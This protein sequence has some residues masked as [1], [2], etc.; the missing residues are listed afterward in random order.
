MNDFR[1]VDYEAIAM[2]NVSATQQIKKEN[3]AEVK[4]LQEENA[5]LRARLAALEAK[6]KT[7]DSKLAAIEKLLL[8]AGNDKPAART[9]SL[10]AE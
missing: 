6:E 1:V 9:V 8:S 2:L 4:A 7:R 3:D 5:S 10:K